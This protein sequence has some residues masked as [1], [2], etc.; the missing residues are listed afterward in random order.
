MKGVKYN[1]KIKKSS[2]EYIIYEGLPMDEACEKIKTEMKNLY[3]IDVKCNNQTIYNLQFRQKNVNRL[4]RGFVSISK[5]NKE[6][7]L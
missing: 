4:L 7:K 6:L 3:D 2:S 5:K 1:L